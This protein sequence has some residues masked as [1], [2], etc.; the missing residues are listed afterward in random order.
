[1]KPQLFLDCDGVLADFNG[2]FIELFGQNPQDFE[3][4]HGTAMFWKS[5]QTHGS[6]FRDLPLMPDAKRLWK[7]CAPWKPIILTGSPQGK[8]APPQKVWWAKHNLHTDRIIVCESKKK[9]NF[10]K[11]GDI[12]VDDLLKYKHLWE[13]MGGVFVHH[14]N[15]ETTKRKLE[16]LLWVSA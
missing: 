16:E 11:P 8:W 2:H 3:D 9:K 5:I 12:L 7:F 4:E 13:G 6:F 14:V 1:L 15:F 10:G